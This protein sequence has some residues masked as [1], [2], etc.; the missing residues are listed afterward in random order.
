[1]YFSRNRNQ[2]NSPENNASLSKVCLES[3]ELFEDL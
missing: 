2:K 3:S 1:M